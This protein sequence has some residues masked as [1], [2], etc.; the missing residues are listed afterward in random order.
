MKP[1]RAVCR[2]PVRKANISAQCSTPEM[3][4]IGQESQHCYEAEEYADFLRR[5]K[6]R[7]A[8]DY[9]HP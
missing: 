8:E 4:H 7:L 1:H 3:S 5:H 6:A 2:L 9:L